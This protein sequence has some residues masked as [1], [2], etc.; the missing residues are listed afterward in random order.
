MLAAASAVVRN[1]PGNPS[2]ATMTTLASAVQELNVL[3]NT[4]GGYHS[5]F[6]GATGE[7]NVDVTSRYVAY[8]VSGV[9]RPPGEF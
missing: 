5:V 4:G 3:H 2:A 6:G 8:R 1:A 7:G 9:T